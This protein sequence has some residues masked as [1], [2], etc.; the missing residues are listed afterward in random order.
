V[1]SAQHSSATA[2][3]GTPPVFVDLVHAV[4]GLP[5]VD[6][7]SSPEWNELVRARRV[8]TA[9]ESGIRTPWFEGAPSPL[10]LLT[11]T[12]KTPDGRRT[13]MINP[14]GERKGALVAAFWIATAGY[15]ARGWLTSAIWIGFSLE[16]LARLQR[17][18]ARSHPLQHLTLLPSERK[19]YRPSPASLAVAEQPTHASFVTLLT[20]SAREADAFITH[21][22]RLGHVARGEL[23]A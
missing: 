7:A 8:I 23:A 14:P 13:A 1:I 3:H 11:S 9:A 10:K 21:G 12:V 15:F 17:V 19:G 2:Q 5:D 16:Q 6:P 4:I 18:G 20:R 22:G